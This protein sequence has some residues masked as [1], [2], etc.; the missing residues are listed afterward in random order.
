MMVNPASLEAKLAE[1]RVHA[2]RQQGSKSSVRSKKQARKG[3][4]A[5]K[6]KRALNAKYLGGN[7]ALEAK[8][9]GVAEVEF[10]AALIP[11]LMV[12]TA[13]LH[14]SVKH[15]KFVMAAINHL[16]RQLKRPK[17]CFVPA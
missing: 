9:L 2:S 7:V 8:P 4:A 15:S 11:R 16:I 10:T 1:V 13:I 12:M 6:L 17:K 14:K 5:R 3:H